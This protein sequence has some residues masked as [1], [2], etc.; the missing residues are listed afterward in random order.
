MGL[1][2]ATGLPIIVAVTTVAVGA[3]EM[4]LTNASVLVAGGAVTVL[5]C[6]L[7]AQRLLKARTTLEIPRPSPRLE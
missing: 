3:G 6:P 2:G 5:I 4:T 1:F 7:L